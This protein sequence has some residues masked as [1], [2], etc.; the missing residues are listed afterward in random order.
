M[1][2]LGINFYWWS[3]SERSSWP[4]RCHSAVLECKHK[5]RTFAT[6][7]GA[8]RKESYERFTKTS[9]AGCTVPP[10]I[11]TNIAISVVYLTNIP[12]N[13]DSL[14]PLLHPLGTRVL[15]WRLSRPNA[16]GQFTT[17]S[18]CNMACGYGK[19]SLMT[20]YGLS[21]ADRIYAVPFDQ[22]G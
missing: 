2:K 18:P 3:E 12:L 22:I 9:K 1:Q 8:T 10:S 16:S 11:R 4:H 14:R 13:N 19:S 21:S 5:I 17:Y 20:Y 6:G 15:E 7:I